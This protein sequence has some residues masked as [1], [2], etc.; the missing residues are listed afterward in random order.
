VAEPDGTALRYR[1][2]E[3]I[4][5]F[6]A[7]RLADAG[8]EQIAAARAAHCAHYLA[9]AETAAPH[10][11][12]PQQGSWWDRLDADQAN[13]RRAAEHAAGEPDGTARVLRFGVALRRYWMV[14]DRNEEAAELLVPV[15]GRPEAA[16]DPALFA[17][18]LT[19]VAN[20]T[21]MADLPT[22]LRLAEQADEIAGGLGDDRLLIYSRVMLCWAYCF[23]G[24]PER[25]RPLGAEAVQRARRLGDDELLGLSLSACAAALDVAASGPLYAEAFACAERSGDL[26]AELTLHSNAGVDALEMGDIPSARAHI[27][28]AIR[29]AEARRTP[30]PVLSVNL[31]W[32]LRAER[33]PDGA[34]S[35]LQDALRFGR[36]IGDKR[37][38]AEAMDGLALLDGDLGDW[39]RAAMLHG[40][41]QAL[42]DQTGA[43]WDPLGARD[44]QESLDQAGAALGDEQFHRAYARGMALG[45]DQAIG[46][47]LNGT[48]PS[49]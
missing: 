37:S 5:L 30:Y 9:V 17:E 7:E 10:L 11:I 34:R 28:A 29:A 40:A 14:R 31:G 16:A 13:L 19:V 27:E 26:G 25:A 43:P 44:R 3:T 41:A 12:G 32:I 20:Y 24:Q 47:A 38:M 6:A 1:L 39:P 35:A 49:T 36:R 8:G 4:R 48:P 18:A 33:D 23:A 42:L 45:F 46:L 15:L 21:M 2:L 22:G